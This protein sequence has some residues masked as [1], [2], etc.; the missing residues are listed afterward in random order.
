MKNF[1][2]L[3]SNDFSWKGITSYQFKS[4]WISKFSQTSLTNY[5]DDY[6]ESLTRDGK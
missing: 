2:N 3:I 6:F 4:S 1:S 5:L